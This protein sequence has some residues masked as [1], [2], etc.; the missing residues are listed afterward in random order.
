MAGVSDD[1]TAIRLPHEPDYIARTIETVRNHRNAGNCWPQWANIFADQIEAYEQHV[2]GLERQLAD[3]REALRQREQVLA[4]A[5]DMLL[6]T[7]RGSE[8]MAETQDVMVLRA[9]IK[10]VA[11]LSAGRVAT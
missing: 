10:A 4:V 7:L 1:I 8:D 9:D 11:A 5:H 2:A 3:T 6:A